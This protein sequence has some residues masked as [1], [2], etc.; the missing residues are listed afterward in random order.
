MDE[1]TVRHYTTA[2]SERTAAYERAEVSAIHERMLHHFGEGTRLLEIGCGS[3]RDAAFLA[4]HGRNVTATDASEGMIQAARQGHPE[5]ARQFHCLPFPFPVGSAMQGQTF[6]GVYAIAVIMHVP[7]EELFEFAFQIKSALRPGGTALLTFSTER[8]G[9]SDGRDSAGRLF[10]ERPPGRLRLLFERLGFRVL[11]QRPATDGMGRDIHWH[12]LVL[13]LADD[14]GNSPVDQ[15]ETVINRDRKDATYK[16]ALLRALCDIAQTEYHQAAWGVDDTVSVPLGLVAEKWLL[17]Y[18]PIVEADL[19]HEGPGVAIPQKRGLEI[20]KPI[21]FRA[22]LLALVRH[23]CTGRGGLDAF[24][25]GFRNG[26]LPP[27]TAVLADAAANKLANTIVAGPVRYSGGAIDD[28]RP[29]FWHDGPITHKGACG[30]SQIL[31]SALGRIHMRGEV[32]RELALVGHWIA[33]AIV[34]RWAELTHEISRRQV[35][36]ADVVGRLLVSPATERDQQRVRDLYRGLP[37]LRCVWTEDAIGPRRG[38][39]IDHIIPFSLWHNNDLWNLVPATHEA[40]NQKRDRLVSRERLRDSRDLILDYWQ[41]TRK[42]SQQVFDYE[43]RR[44][45]LPP[46]VPTANWELSAFSAL[47]EAIESVA[48]QRGIPRWPECAPN[49]VSLAMPAASQTGAGQPKHEEQP[50]QPLT[51][52]LPVLS[53]HEVEGRGFVTALPLVAELAAG[54]PYDGFTTRSLDA[55]DWLDVPEELAGKDR[56]IIQ[57]NG[58]SMEPGLQDGDYVVCQYHRTP[59]RPGQVVIMGGFDDGDG[60]FAIK[61]FNES[62][63]E[64]LFH[65]DNPAYA[66]IRIAKVDVP[67]H[68]ILGVAIHNLTRDEPV[69]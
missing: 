36:I 17:Y 1:R 31:V 58:D 24:H 57:V 49:T 59:R 5:M 66:P 62:R 45:L 68:P 54:L 69:R 46:S 51:H 47:S 11:E 26:T 35:P 53:R 33:E 43:I 2:A 7:E 65:S 37:D 42:A 14:A 13:R 19:A 15:I 10:I 52:D 67:A 40:N 29:F 32:W 27:E 16:L 63:T 28:D 64:W 55:E 3:G 18:W 21:A 38:F 50:V 60:T 9:L 56:F 8:E 25:F 30:S 4:A 39:E 34:L 48:C 6:D 22:E 12:T 23:C 44:S 61:R 20:N 41:T